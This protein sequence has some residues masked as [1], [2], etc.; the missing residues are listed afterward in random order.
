VRE[1]L[2][3]IERG[4]LLSPLLVLQTLATNKNLTL[5]VVKEYVGRCLAEDSA[6]L[7][8]DQVPPPSPTTSTAPLSTR[9][10]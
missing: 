1:A 9:H 5:S 4:R 8:E 3:H 6:A 7:A 10:V 2:V